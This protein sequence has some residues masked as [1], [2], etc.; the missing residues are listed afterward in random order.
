MASTS[1]NPFVT[2]P[3]IETA[4]VFQK[5]ARPRL[6]QLVANQ[7]EEAILSQTFKAGERLPSE[8]ALANQF[9]VS[10]NIVR[11]AF[12]MLQERGLIQIISG[13]G[14]FVSYPNSEATADAL[15]RYIRWLGTDQSIKALYEV[16]RILEGAN[17]RLAAQ[18]NDEQDLEALETCLTR[19]R[20]N[21]ASLEKWV[22]ADLE[23]HLAIAR[24]THNPF[25]SLLLEP[26]VDQ[27]HEVI[28]GGYLVPGAVD[29]G[30]EAHTRVYQCIKNKDPEGAYNAIMD[31]L[32]DS[33]LRI[34][35][36]KEK[37]K[38]GSNL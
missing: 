38:S 13:S 18:R 24:A 15:G 26:L 16:R 29:T 36:Y 25:L 28:A 1:D 27:L 34:E 30:L 17:A 12:K 3:N 6:S 19:M 10:R 35:A 4:K 23:F 8:Q 20:L 31:H 21:K 32:H 7:I 11:E 14:A 37:L 33:E 5:I 2:N 9:G 22:E